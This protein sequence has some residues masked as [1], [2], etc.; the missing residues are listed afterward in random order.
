MD[1]SQAVQNRRVVAVAECS[2]DGHEAFACELPDQSHGD[3]ASVGCC[4]AL[5]RAGD[6]LWRQAV[7][8]CRGCD[9]MA[10]DRAGPT[11]AAPLSTVCRACKRTNEGWRW[12]R[13]YN[14]Q[15]AAQPRRERI[16][17]RWAHA[18]MSVERDDPLPP[19]GGTSVE[20]IGEHLKGFGV[21][22]P[23]NCI[24]QNQR[25]GDK[26]RPPLIN[27]VV[28][29]CRGNFP[30]ERLAVPADCRH[31]IFVTP[32]RT[33]LR[34]PPRLTRPWTANGNNWVVAAEPSLGGG[35]CGMFRA[36]VK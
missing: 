17:K 21:N 11:D 28:V 34:Q 2:P 31:V 32:S 10:D 25:P 14:E 36:E 7:A 12:V 20:E 35:L 4:A 16:A 33:D 9:R 22:D 15:P 19:N 27:R 26:S 29:K 8:A 24:D 18:G 13:Q 23:I 3:A 6:L 5:G 30:A 1:N